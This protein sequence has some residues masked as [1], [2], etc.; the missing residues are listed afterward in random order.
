MKQCEIGGIISHR[1]GYGFKI[2]FDTIKQA[3]YYKGL[4]AYALREDKYK[5]KNNKGYHDKKEKQ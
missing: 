5:I 3:Q 4:L 2:R 1:D